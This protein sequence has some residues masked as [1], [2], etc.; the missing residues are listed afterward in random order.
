MLTRSES[1]YFAFRSPNG[2]RLGSRGKAIQ[3]EASIVEFDFEK[4]DARFAVTGDI[5]SVRDLI[6]V[7]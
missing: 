4:R 1:P 2:V 7:V 3:N 6:V 5:I